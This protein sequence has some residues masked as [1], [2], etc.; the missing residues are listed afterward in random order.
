MPTAPALAT[1]TDWMHAANLT[2]LAGAGT[3]ADELPDIAYRDLFAAGCTPAEAAEEAL[4]NADAPD[5]LFSYLEEA[6][7]LGADDNPLG[8][9]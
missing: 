4:A 6:A 9:W 8:E 3:L 7:Y 2:L 1:F 5:L